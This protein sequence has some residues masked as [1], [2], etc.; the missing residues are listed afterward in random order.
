MFNKQKHK[1][2]K[3]NSRNYI[4]FDKQLALENEKLSHDDGKIGK[5]TLNE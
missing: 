3:S 1:I 5:V 4:Y 2:V